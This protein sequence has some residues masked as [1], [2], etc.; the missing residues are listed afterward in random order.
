VGEDGVDDKGVGLRPGRMTERL[1][2]H[3]QHGP[4]RLQ[5]PQ[6]DPVAVQGE[7]VKF[8][9]A[10]TRRPVPEGIRRLEVIN[11]T[12]DAGCEVRR[13]GFHVTSLWGEAA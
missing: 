6:I 3:A 1:V 11:P 10:D 8:P 13:Y 7:S 9:L 5:R 4:V 12:L 2:I